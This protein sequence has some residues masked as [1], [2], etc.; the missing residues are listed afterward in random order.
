MCAVLVYNLKNCRDGS[1]A[2]YNT[3]VEITSSNGRL[4]F[5]FVAKNS[6]CF[7]PYHNYN[8]LH[9]EGDACELLIGTDPER[10]QYYEIEISPENKLMIALMTYCGDDEEGEPQLKLDFVQKSFIDSRIT[11]T[12]DGY[13]AELWFDERYIR[14]SEDDIYFNAYRLET[15]GG[16]SEKHL[17]AL[18]H[19]MRGKFHTPEY[20]VYLKDY[21][22]D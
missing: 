16:E 13:I 21:I 5:K 8:N 19:T 3:T 15:D 17:F 1:K 9:S 20:F 7:C 11:L 22:G 14:T 12:Q 4:Y 10:R 18:S 6:Q 2:T